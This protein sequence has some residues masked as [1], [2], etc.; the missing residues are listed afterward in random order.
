MSDEFGLLL[1]DDTPLLENDATALDQDENAPYPGDVEAEA[2]A[3][4]SDLLAGFKG[5]ARQEDQRVERAVDSE[6]WFCL[7]FQTRQMK[8]EFLDKLHLKSLGD[9]YLDGMEVA[10]VLGIKLESPVPPMPKTRGA[11]DLAALSLETDELPDL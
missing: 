3:E 10:K 7:C 4:M 6:Y 8:E 9:K 2:V 1:D 11:D 5:R